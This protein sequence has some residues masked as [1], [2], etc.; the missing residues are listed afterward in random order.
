MEDIKKDSDE[1]IKKFV[2]KQKKLSKELYDWQKRALDFFFENNQGVIEASTGVGKTRCAI[3]IMRKVFE[4]DPDCRCLIMVPKNVILETGWYKELYE[5][6]IHLRDIGVYYGAVKEES[7]ITITNMQSVK[8]LNHKKYDMIILDEIHNYGTSKLLPL[9]EHKFKYK[10]GLTATLERMDGNHWKIL[11]CFDYWRFKYTPK[12][13]LFD[14]V[15]NP[16]DFVNISIDLDP[17]TFEKYTEVDMKLN[18]IL[19]AGGGFQKIMRSDSGMKYKMLGLMNERKALVN[20]YI[21]KFNIVKDICFRHKDDKVIVFNEYNDTTNKTYWHL[22][23]VGIKTCVIHSG[24]NSVKREQYL[25]DFKNDKYQ[26]MLTSKVLDEGYNLP[27]LDVAIISA[28][29]STARQT[30]QRMGRVLRKKNKNSRL[31][32]I[33]CKDTIEEDYAIERS[34]MFKELSN[35]FKQYHYN[36]QGVKSEVFE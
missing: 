27:K 22:L 23:D 8:N 15:L 33:Y 26:V 31:Y 4:I 10:L 18:S 11:E 2:K 9:L 35:T 34:K 32:Q 12:Q 13:A 25:I 28:G 30:I 7:K 29:N 20:N 36:S 3:E 21:E 19:K 16:F 1:E 5:A 14:N 24:I 17:T 6:G